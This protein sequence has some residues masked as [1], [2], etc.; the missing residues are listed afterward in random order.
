MRD[1]IC[2]LRCWISLQRAFSTVARNSRSTSSLLENNGVPRGRN[3]VQHSDSTWST[4]MKVFLPC[5]AIIL[6]LMEDFATRKSSNEHEFSVTVTSLNKIGE[7]RIWDHTGDVPFPVT[8]KCIML[9]AVASLNKIGEGGI[10]DHIGAL[11]PTLSGCKPNI[12]REVQIW[13]SN[14]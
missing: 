7:G 14:L 5:K 2:S 3:T 10:W 8:F 4:G 1:C 9:I 11:C 13:E 6:R 12:P